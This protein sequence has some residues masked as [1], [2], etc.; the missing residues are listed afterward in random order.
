MRQDKSIRR[1][2]C[3]FCVVMLLSV[4]GKQGARSFSTVATNSGRRRFLFQNSGVKI[5]WN[6]PRLFHTT[7][8]PTST[9]LQALADVKEQ[10]QNSTLASPRTARRCANSATSSSTQPWKKDL[11]DAQLEAVTKPL[12]SI[13]RVIAGTKDLFEILVYCLDTV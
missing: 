9:L 7:T 12:C 4:V 5:T 3:V 1:W 10:Y 13:T 2:M 6:S 8:R 11:N